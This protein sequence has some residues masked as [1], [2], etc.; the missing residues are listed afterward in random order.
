[1]ICHICNKKI[2]YYECYEIV[3]GQKVHV[4]CDK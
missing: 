4:G 2:S 1:M 3:N